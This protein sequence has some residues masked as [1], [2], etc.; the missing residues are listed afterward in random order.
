MYIALFSIHGLIR[1]HDLELG[2]DADTGGQTKY[3]VELSKTLAQQ[4]GIRR[5]DLF[6][7]QVIDPKVSPD[8][9]KPCE[10][11]APNTYIIR[12]LCGPRRYLR[13]E[14]LW[15]YLDHFADR[16]LQHFRRVGLPDILHAHYADAGYVAFKLSH[17]LGIPLIFTGHSLGRIKKKRL[18]EKGMNA[19]RIEER[20]SFHERIEAEENTL[21]AASMVVTSTNQE[22]TDQYQ[23]YEN[24]RPENMVVIPPG[25]DL[26]RF[27]PPSSSVRDYPIANE[28]NRFLRNP[29]KP[30]ILAISRADERKN[31]STLIRAYGENP[32]L[33]DVA[34]LAVVAGNRDDLHTLDSGSREVFARILFTIDRYDLYGSVAY[35]KHHKPD[36][37]PDLYRIAVRT[38]GVFVNPALTEPFGLT[39]LEAAA[40]GLPIVATR[41]GGPLDIIRHC[42]NGFLI[43]PLHADEMSAAILN[44]LSDRNSWSELSQYGLRGVHRHYSWTGHATTYLE[45]IQEFITKKPRPFWIHSG[46]KIL[47]ADRMLVTDIDNTLLGQPGESGDLDALRELMERIAGNPYRIGFGIATGRR[48]ESAVEILEKWEV[49]RPDVLI[50]SVGSEIHYGDTLKQDYDWKKHINFKWEPNR[51]QECLSQ[52]PGLQIQPDE[53]QRLHK[54]SYF[55]DTAKAP[56][57]REIVRILRKNNFQVE[58]IFSHQQFLD[59]LPIRASKGLAIWYLA[60][61]WGIPLE[62]WLVAGDSGNDEEML[63]THVLGVVVGNY[64]PELEHLRNRPGIYFAQ[65]HYA[66]GI[67]EGIYHYRFLD[68]IQIPEGFVT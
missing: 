59:F 52:F 58:T 62:R 48:L 28:I 13:K 15:P 25:I 41:D 24:Y 17:F 46:K 3:V 53:E 4:P 35:P 27:T 23:S 38:G 55:V 34:N 32:R 65:A 68:D 56:K 43:D 30:L 18:L 11:I 42:R 22:I 64:S 60:N 1:G 39:L 20:Y 37:V 49:P 12:I 8:Y 66:R 14:V 36:D 16:I 54:I 10:E 2:R 9:A 29:E 5:V 51:L 31:I 47:Q 67:L 44:I 7:R 61:K 45:H 63:T 6:T 21:N 57:I 40:S 50:T 19:E 26:Q 33:R